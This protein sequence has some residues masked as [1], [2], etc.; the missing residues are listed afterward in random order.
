M[1]QAQPLALR[2]RTSGEDSSTLELTL[3]AWQPFLDLNPYATNFVYIW[4][5]Q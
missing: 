4:S 1:L 2:Q 5:S 3:P